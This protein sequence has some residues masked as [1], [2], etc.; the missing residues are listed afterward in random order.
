VC[1]CRGCL[2]INAICQILK[3]TEIIKIISTFCEYIH[4]AV[5]TNDER[6]SFFSVLNILRFYS[7]SLFQS[8]GLGVGGC[9]KGLLLL[10]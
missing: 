8:R 9:R 2:T 3:E 6:G 10:T 5:V 4:H 7:K 1:S